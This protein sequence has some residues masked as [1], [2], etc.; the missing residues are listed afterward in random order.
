MDTIFIVRNEELARLSPADA[1][2]FF[3]EL[4]WAEARSKG[5]AVSKSHISTSINVPDGWVDALVEETDGRIGN[6]LIKAGQT[7]YQIKTGKNF[8]PW[9]DAQ[10]KKELFGDKPPTR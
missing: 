10:I 6:D 3:R 4:L 2:E 9:Q 7:A 5:I 1:V 8:E